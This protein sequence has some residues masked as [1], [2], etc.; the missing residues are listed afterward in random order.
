MPSVDLSEYLADRD[1]LMKQDRALRVDAVKLDDL[2]PT[3]AAAEQIVRDMR[4]EE[5]VSVWGV[6]REGIEHPFPGM[7]FLTSRSVIMRT[8]VFNVLHKVSSGCLLSN[9]VAV[10][11]EFVSKMPKGGLLHAHLDATVDVNFLL[12]R[13]L[14]QEALYIRAS[15]PLTTLSPTANV[16][17]EFSPFAQSEVKLSAVQ[18]LTD[19]S[20]D[21]GWIPVNVA[22]DAFSPELGG[23]EGFDKW[24]VAS[25]TINPAEAYGTHKTVAKVISIVKTSF[26]DDDGSS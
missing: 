3:E 14:E 18:S 15:A 17:P 8:K 9:L 6:E 10:L 11:S 19:V 23:P 20:Y 13:I 16:L 12:N 1:K 7:E 2:T 24:Y 5:A 21:G 26:E 25:T 4:A 22:R